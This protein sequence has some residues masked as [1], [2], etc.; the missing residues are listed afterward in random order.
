MSESS[1]FGFIE[2]RLSP[3]QLQVMRGVIRGLTNAE[4]ADHLSVSG[5]TINTHL[6]AALRKTGHATKY[7]LADAIADQYDEIGGVR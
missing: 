1:P 6:K 7:D 2:D 3:Q 4:I 5:N